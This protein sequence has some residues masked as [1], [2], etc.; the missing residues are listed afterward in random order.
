MPTH[1]PYT[2]TTTLCDPSASSSWGLLSLCSFPLLRTD[3]SP[4]QAH[5]GNKRQ[6]TTSKSLIQSYSLVD[7]IV[8]DTGHGSLDPKY[9]PRSSAKQKEQPQM[10]VEGDSMPQHLASLTEKGPPTF[11]LDSSSCIRS[12]QGWNMHPKESGQKRR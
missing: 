8:S 12:S 9:K 10:G 11:C 3:A 1:A 2:L 6:L 4:S 7:E 5:L